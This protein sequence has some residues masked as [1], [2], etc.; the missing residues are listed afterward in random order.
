[1]IPKMKKMAVVLLAL[2]L[3]ATA[4]FPVF[5]ASDGPST[6]GNISR[7]FKATNSA[8]PNEAL[9]VLCSAGNI[10]TGVSVTTWSAS[11]NDVTQHFIMRMGSHGRCLSPYANQNY[12]V[13]KTSA[14]YAELRPIS[15]QSWN[16]EENTLSGSRIYFIG[17]PSLYGVSDDR[18][19]GRFSQATSYNSASNP[20]Y[21]CTFMQRSENTG[22]DHFPVSY[23]MWNYEYVG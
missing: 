23:C 18:Y 11:E 19:L 9:N 10:S 17:F 2:A 3:I 15:E 21:Y 5:A 22:S 4:A 7:P 6:R 12:Y 8:H 13:H 16:V 14:G 20:S 1:M